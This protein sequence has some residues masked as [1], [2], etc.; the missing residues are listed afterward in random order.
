MVVAAIGWTGDTSV[1]SF[2]FSLCLSLFFFLSQRDSLLLTLWCGRKNLFLLSFFTSGA[3]YI[4]T[5]SILTFFLA[6]NRL[7]RFL[8]K[9]TSNPNP[10]HGKWLMDWKQFIRLGR[11][12]AASFASAGEARRGSFHALAKPSVRYLSLSCAERAPLRT[13]MWAEFWVTDSRAQKFSVASHDIISVCYS[14]V[15]LSIM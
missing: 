11:T 4:L 12:H 14:F 15:F 2:S 3:S 10:R 8:E 1:R 6:A 13:A 5:P 7:T 9:K